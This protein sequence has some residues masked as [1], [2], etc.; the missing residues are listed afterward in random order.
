MRD[1]MRRLTVRR[2]PFSPWEERGIAESRRQR[3]SFCSIH[4]HRAGIPVDV[5][6]V[7]VAT[8]VHLH[9]A[10][11]KPNCESPGLLAR[12]D[13]ASQYVRQILQVHGKVY[14]RAV[15]LLLCLE[16]RNILQQASVQMI[17]HVRVNGIDERSTQAESKLQ[18]EKKT[19]KL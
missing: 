11:S 6:R 17:V 7:Y 14:D 5:R 16:I 12:R 19:K 10:T 8:A 1:P 9:S 18:T 4:Q 2:V 3:A 13:R 15:V